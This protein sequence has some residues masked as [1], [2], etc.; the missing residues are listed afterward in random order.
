M[1]ENENSQETISTTDYRYT[2]TGSPIRSI[3][4]RR[5]DRLEAV[6]PHLLVLLRQSE[7][8]WLA[9]GVTVEDHTADLV[10]RA[11]APSCPPFIIDP[12]DVYGE[13]RLPDGS[14]LILGLIASLFLWAIIIVGI[15]AIL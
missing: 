9:D 15:R 2:I 13:P 10:D 4:R 7:R 14:G 12:A 6:S 8:E 11:E 3:E 5:P 1:L